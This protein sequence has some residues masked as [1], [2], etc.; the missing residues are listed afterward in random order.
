LHIQ[1]VLSA[2]HADTAGLSLPAGTAVAGDSYFQ[3]AAAVRFNLRP[4]AGYAAELSPI[5][6]P[7]LDA[8]IAINEY[9]LGRSRAEYRTS[10]MAAIWT[11]AGGREARSEAARLERLAA[12][13]AAWDAVAAVPA[14][15]T[16]RF[17]IR[18]LA[19]PAGAKG[20]HLSP[21][22]EL[23]RRGKRWD[24]WERPR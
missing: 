16:D 19:L 9:L 6:D 20:S 8:R 18:V 5:P 4:L 14:A 11:K 3:S 24:V 7:E 15:A 22:W 13:L 21:G 2:F 17:F 23:R 1:E 12:R 10:E